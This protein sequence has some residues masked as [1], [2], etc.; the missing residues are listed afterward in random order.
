MP[1]LEFANRFVA[2]INFV[3]YGSRD[4]VTGYE[5]RAVEVFETFAAAKAFVDAQNESGDEWMDHCFEIYNSVSRAVISRDPDVPLELPMRD[6]AAI[7][8]ED[9]DD[10][11]LPF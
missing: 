2:R 1:R 11:D 6:L 7:F 3:T 10:D 4:E 9:D 8:S 5:S